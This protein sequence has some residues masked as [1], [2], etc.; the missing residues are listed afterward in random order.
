M[1]FDAAEAKRITGPA[2]LD[3]VG[4]TDGW[5][6]YWQEAYRKRRQ[7]APWNNFS[8]AAE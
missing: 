1:T 4:P 3:G 5:Q 6:S 8:T 7:A 2:T